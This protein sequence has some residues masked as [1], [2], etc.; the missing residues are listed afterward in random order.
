MAYICPHCHHV[1]PVGVG[2]CKEAKEQIDRDI[3]NMKTRIA[4]HRD[5]CRGCPDP[6]QHLLNLDNLDRPKTEPRYR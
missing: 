6:Q 5:Q 1:H 2:S 3:A 4:A